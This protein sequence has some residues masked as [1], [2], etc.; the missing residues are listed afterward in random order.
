M[1]QQVFNRTVEKYGTSIVY[2]LSPMVYLHWE[3]ELFTL[4]CFYVLF[5]ICSV[6]FRSIAALQ[7]LKQYSKAAEALFINE[8]AR[9]RL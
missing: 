4:K 9:K 6:I 8:R 3:W 7:L 1:S 2:G 5:H